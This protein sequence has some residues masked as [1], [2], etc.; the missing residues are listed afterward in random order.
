MNVDVLM[1]QPGLAV[2]VEGIARFFRLHR[3]WEAA[4]PQ[5]LLAQVGPQVRALAVGPRTVVD[6]P[7]LARF[8]NLEIVSS[9]GVGYDHIDVGA[10]RR[11]NVVV[12]HTPD[13]LN[14]EVADTCIG[15]LLATVRQLP[16]AD[17][18]V[19]SGAWLQR[20]FAPTASLR[21][22]TIG[23]LGLGR[24]GTVIARR[25]E[26]FDVAIAYHSRSPRD[27]AYRYFP[28][29]LELAKHV[30]TLICVAPGNPQ[31]KHLVDAQVLEALGPDGILINVGR[32]SLVDERALI[33]AL[34]T[35]KI[36]SAGL[37]VYENEPHV[38]PQ[39]L[40]MPHVVL[41]PHIG[42]ASL[43]TRNAMGQLVVDNLVDWFSGRGPRTP[44]AETPWRAE[45]TGGTA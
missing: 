10:A 2:I 37:D 44:V 15:L 32:G 33:A 45:V 26:A 28:T 25:L 24:I 16:Q 18:H 43:H 29:L 19:R 3:L 22:R 38:P 14:E 21:G 6:E 13:V 35:G 5:Q 7:L 9:F 40:K 31:T 23:I 34:E 11:H 4:D 1:P 42:T 12:T 20:P 39:L 30:D 8:P 27:V 17:L 36:L 41:F